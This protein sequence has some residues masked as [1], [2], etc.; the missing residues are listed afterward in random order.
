MEAVIEI[1][2]AQP[3]VREGVGVGLTL[4]GVLGFLRARSGR[5]WVAPACL[6]ASLSLTVSVTLFSWRGPGGEG[7][8]PDPLSRCRVAVQWASLLAEMYSPGGLLNIALFAPVGLFAALLWRRTVV[9]VLGAAALSACIEI[10]QALGGGHDCTS[11]DTIANT[12]G[13]VLGVGLA[14]VVTSSAG[15]RLRA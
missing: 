13:A 3:E 12:A 7:P 6:V 1:L 2:W 5:S 8:G 14:W 15:N 10:A 9:V 11:T 4:A